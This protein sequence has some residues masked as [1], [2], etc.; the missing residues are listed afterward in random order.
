MDEIQ[1]AHLVICNSSDEGMLPCRKRVALLNTVCCL[2][3][4]SYGIAHSTVYK[5]TLSAPRRSIRSPC[6]FGDVPL[7]DAAWTHSRHRCAAWRGGFAA[8]AAGLARLPRA[9][10]AKAGAASERGT[11][12][13]ASSTLLT[14]ETATIVLAIEGVLRS[15]SSEPSV[16]I[17][18]G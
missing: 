6:P 9:W 2:V 15:C 11:W 14:H 1:L 4:I 16:G 12:R 10:T 7:L 3:T 5:N 18:K 13:T 8:N 17:G